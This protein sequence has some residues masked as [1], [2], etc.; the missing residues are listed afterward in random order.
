MQYIYISVFV[1][2]N[3]EDSSEE[4]EEEEEESDDDDEEEEEKY[5]GDDEEEPFT[6]STP[7]WR[8]NK[9]QDIPLSDGDRRAG[10]PINP[11]EYRDGSILKIFARVFPVS[12]LQTMVDETNRY[13]VSCGA[14]QLGREWESVNLREMQ[15]WLGLWQMMGIFRL[16]LVQALTS[17]AVRFVCSKG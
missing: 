10:A 8:L 2:E 17:G 7:S 16:P 6:A 3:V 4:E 15:A 5:E 14:G 1:A 12:V 11:R 13:A 9:H